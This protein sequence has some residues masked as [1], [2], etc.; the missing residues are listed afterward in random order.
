MLGQ[1]KVLDGF[2][3]KTWTILSLTE[4]QNRLYRTITRRFRGWEKV[5]YGNTRTPV[6][7]K[8][9]TVEFTR[10]LFEKGVV[11][12]GSSRFYVDYPLG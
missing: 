2:P 12:R 7:V 10:Q 3:S 4:S 6:N 9:I 11:P 1:I 8:L 5:K